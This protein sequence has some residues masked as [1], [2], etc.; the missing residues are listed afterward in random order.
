MDIDAEEDHTF[1]THMHAKI[2][3]AVLCWPLI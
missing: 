1:S 2:T 3:I